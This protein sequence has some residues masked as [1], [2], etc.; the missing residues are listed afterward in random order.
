MAKK[1][2]VDVEV[3]AASQEAL[4]ALSA[5]YPQADSY[6]RNAQSKIVFK[7]KDIFGDKLNA[8]GEVI[9]DEDEEPEQAL[10]TKAGTF[11]ADRPDLEDAKADWVK[12]KLGMKI[13]GH[14]IYARRRLQMYD[15]DTEEMTTSP[16]FDENTEVL[17][18]FKSGEFVASGTPAELKAM[19]PTTRE[20]T[21][22]N[23]EKKERKGSLLQEAKILYVVVD[24]ELLELTLRG[25][26][27][28]SY[29][30]YAKTTLVE[31]TVTGFSSEKREKGSNKWNCMM[32]ESAR[33]LTA[34]EA[35]ANVAVLREIVEVFKEEKE[36]YA[37][38]RA[39]NAEVAAPAIQVAHE[40]V[41]IAAPKEMTA[42]A[43]ED[44]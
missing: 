4:D 37:A 29:Q 16:I 5:M 20:Y 31:R 8:K 11:F 34:D 21:D 39:E 22:K 42:E 18:L 6:H 2:E 12:E 40:A 41:A 36:F 13:E 25:S 44:F 19:Y 26:S 43:D 1:T 27:M 10:I 14:I 38:K 15:G 33:D 9:L 3:L 7:S 28:Y 24:G 30:D 35:I 23:G 32:F 17:P